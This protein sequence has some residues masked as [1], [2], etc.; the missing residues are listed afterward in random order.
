[1]Y[2]FKCFSLSFPTAALTDKNTEN[3]LLVTYSQ[4]AHSSVV[5]EAGRSR[6][7]VPMRW[8]FLNL[9]NP[10]GRTMALG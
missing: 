10:S 6:D 2:V 8:I 3:L 4:G 1:M 9:N 5:V 7:R